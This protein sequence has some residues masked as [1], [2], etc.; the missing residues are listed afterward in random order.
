MI[1]LS[2]DAQGMKDHYVGGGGDDEDVDVREKECED[3]EVVKCD[4][5]DYELS[6]V[7][8]NELVDEREKEREHVED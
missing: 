5:R 8:V 3:E 4:E 2:D 1:Q 7:S 6:V